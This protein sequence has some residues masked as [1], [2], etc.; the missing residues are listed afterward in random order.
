MADKIK[1]SSPA[2]LLPLENE[3]FHTAYEDYFKRKRGN[4]FRSM[5]EF[6]ELWDDLQLPIGSAS[7]CASRPQ[8]PLELRR[9]RLDDRLGRMAVTIR[10]ICG[11]SR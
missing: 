9:P 1:K 10:K 2:E 4:F 5:T 7:P 11:C 8:K 6:K 3:H